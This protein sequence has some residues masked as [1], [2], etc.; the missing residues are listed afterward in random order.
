MNGL[1]GTGVAFALAAGCC[2]PLL[3]G[4]LTC[5]TGGGPVPVAMPLMVLVGGLLLSA[6]PE[7]LL[8]DGG[9]MAGGS[10][11]SLS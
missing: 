7:A 6:L 10:L 4:C 3:T 11:A 8:P 9:S 5:A 2:E 1:G